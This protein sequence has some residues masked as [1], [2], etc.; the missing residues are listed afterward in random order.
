MREEIIKRNKIF[1]TMKNTHIH[2]IAIVLMAILTLTACSDDFLEQV[3][4]NQLSTASFWKNR[5]DLDVGLIAVYSSLKS[6]NTIRMPDENNRTDLTYPGFGRPNPTNEYYL[7]TFN[8]SSDAPNSKWQFLYQGIFRANQV[9]VAAERL[10]GTHPNAT[11]ENAA[12]DILAQA[13]GLRGLFYFYLHNSFN[14]GSVVIYDFVPEKE[15]DFFQPL[16]SASA[17]EAFYLQDLEYAYNNLPDSWD[18]SNLGRITSGAAAA[19][20]GKSYLYA[21]NYTEAQNWFGKVINDYSYSLTPNIGSNFTTMDE[22]N[23]E[24]ILEI[25]YS[26]NYKDEI[27]AYSGEQ[28]SSTNNFLIS[29]VGG[30][31]TL[32]PACWLTMKYKQDPMDATDVRNL[33]DD[34][35]GGLTL[36]K[37]SLRTSYSLALPDDEDLY[38]YIGEVTQDDGSKVTQGLTPAQSAPFNN[39][40]YAYFRKY[41]NWDFAESERTISAATPR[42]GVNVRLIRLADVY[43]MYAESILMNDGSVDEALIYV[44]RVRQRS[45]LQ[46]LGIDGT[47]EYSANSHDN[48][49]HTTGK[50]GTLMQHLVYTE[51]PLELSIEGN[52]IRHIDLRRWVENG[53]INKTMNDHFL[54]LSQKEYY[55]T[56]HT[57]TTAANKSGTKW[58]AVLENDGGAAADENFKE[59]HL[60]AQN[61]IKEAHAYWPIPNSEITANPKLSE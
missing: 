26:L 24:S 20:I 50:S 55:V 41:T 39:K 6:G 31:R 19:L 44:N 12:N 33:V 58:G 27:D 5:S 56:N 46:L 14:N 21:D 51:R 3:N 52:A 13:R 9:I 48:I 45:G 25:A 15:S 30:W 60:S 42:S 11:E 59:F 37:Y 17:V 40:E 61:Y 38:Y 47:G 8:N 4:P 32:I 7:Q 29:P 28:T 57:Y 23:S 22:F 34:G 53:T 16:S 49:V 1:S 10:Q 2:K 35:A 54:E 43:L 36:R 18:A